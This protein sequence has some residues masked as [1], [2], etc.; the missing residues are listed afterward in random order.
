MFY[1]K[2]CKFLTE[3]KYNYTRH[4]ATNNCIKARQK[5]NIEVFEN[6]PPNEQNVPPNEQNVPP[7]EQNVPPNE[8]NVPL[9][10]NCKKC[11][12]IYKTKKH[13]MNHETKCKG[14][15]ELTC[16][17]CMKSFTTRQHKYRHIQ[18]NNC[19]AKSIIHSRIPNIQNITNIENQ[20][21]TNNN[22]IQ[23]NIIINNFG[24]ERLNH[25]TDEDIQRI[26]TSGI[27]TIPLYIEKKHFDKNFPENNN[28]IYTKENKCKVME[29]DK[30]QEKNLELLSSKLIQDNSEYLLLYYD[31]NKSELSEKILD[32]DIMDHVK[33]KLILIYNKCDSDKYKKILS[34]IKDLIKNFQ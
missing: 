34:I 16:P 7:N 15:D 18:V 2:S 8:Q 9:L 25:I 3:R 14:I 32:E 17:I 6:V 31:E 33:N 19:K 23:N 12:K 20:N 10:Y 29:N 24:N 5:E 27:N 22:N 26:L 1:C 28:I 13:L 4:I 11:N 21:I 30:W